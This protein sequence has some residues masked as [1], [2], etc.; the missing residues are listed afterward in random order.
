MFGISTG[1]GLELPQAANRAAAI[2]RNKKR[3]VAKAFIF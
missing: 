3:M 1:W 2:T